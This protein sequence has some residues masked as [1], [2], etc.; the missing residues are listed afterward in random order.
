MAYVSRL[1]SCVFACRWWEESGFF[2]P[3]AEVRSL[4]AVDAQPLYAAPDFKVCISKVHARPLKYVPD[5]SRIFEGRRA[6]HVRSV[7]DVV[8]AGRLRT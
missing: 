6:L 5:G 1:I 3:I 4:A 8:L 7:G 2:K